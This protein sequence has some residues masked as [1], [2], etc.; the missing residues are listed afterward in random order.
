MVVCEWVWIWAYQSSSSGISFLFTLFF[1]MCL[2]LELTDS[3]TRISQCTSEVPLSPFPLHQAFACVFL[4][5]KLRSSHLCT[6]RVINWVRSFL[7][8]QPASNL[9]KTYCPCFSNLSI[10]YNFFCGMKN[11]LCLHCQSCPILEPLFPHSVK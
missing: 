6:K 8:P 1:E 9:L 2:N 3:A 5:F 11:M 7:Q 4:E 10:C